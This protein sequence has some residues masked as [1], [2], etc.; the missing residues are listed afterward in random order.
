MTMPAEAA[1][2]RF[3]RYRAALLDDCRFGSMYLRQWSRLRQALATSPSLSHIG[4]HFF[5]STVLGLQELVYVHLGRLLDSH[6]DSVN[7]S[8]FLNFV[9]QNPEVFRDTSPADIRRLVARH[10]AALASL[11]DDI[12][13]L[14]YLRDNRYAHRN[15][16][17]TQEQLAASS[18]QQESLRRL[19]DTVARILNDYSGIFDKCEYAMEFVAEDDV[20]RVLRIIEQAAQRPNVSA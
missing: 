15:S 17:V 16:A 18:L 4:Y 1:H 6:K 5:N 19:F 13:T 14:K 2:D 3:I 20:G 12:A 9:E 11:K 8:K 7:I 10:R